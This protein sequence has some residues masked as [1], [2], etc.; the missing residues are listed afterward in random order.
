MTLTY[1]FINNLKM[2]CCQFYPNLNQLTETTFR[3]A[4]YNLPLIFFP[5]LLFQQSPR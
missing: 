3:K 2:G 5:F 4:T 1:D